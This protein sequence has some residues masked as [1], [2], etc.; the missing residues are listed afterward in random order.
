[1]HHPHAGSGRYVTLSAGVA[2]LVPPRELPLEALLKACRSALKRAK[3]VGKNSI[4]TAE[5][6]DFH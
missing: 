6:T 1:M 4:S 5:S 2:S 3:G